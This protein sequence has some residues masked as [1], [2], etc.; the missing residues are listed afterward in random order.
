MTIAHLRT[1]T[2]NNGMMDSWLKLFDETLIDVM[3]G[4]RDEGRDRLGERRR[5]A[6][7]LDPLLRRNRRRT[8]RERGRILWFR[9]VGRQHAARAWTSGAPRHQN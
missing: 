3:A 5:I 6:V 7:H 8:G 9:V 2:I 4:I 1:Y